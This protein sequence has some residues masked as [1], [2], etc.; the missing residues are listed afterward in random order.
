VLRRRAAPA[1]APARGTDDAH[2]VDT[3]GTGGGI[4][5]FN[6]STG[7]AILAASAGA[8]VA[9]HGNRAVTSSCGSADV[10]EALGVNVSSEP[11]GA[12][13]LLD[14]AGIAFFFAPTHHPALRHVGKVRREL[15][16]RTVFN[17]LG[18]LANPAG[19]RRQ[20]VGVY[21]PG[22]VRPMAEALLDLGAE[23]ALVV[24]GEEGLDE[25]SPC[26]PTL[27]ALVAE[28]AVRDGKATPADF[29]LEP[30]S[31]SALEPGEDAAQNA[32]IL[33]EALTD[34]VSPRCGALLPS[35]AA[36]LWLAGLA[37][38]FREGA[39]LA[40]EAVASGRAAKTLERFARESQTP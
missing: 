35:A 31:P 25:I 3:C 33:R 2:L 36:A 10:L 39:R 40:R 5:S 21:E 1:P 23:R 32:R 30:L 22:L 11:E 28:G 9:K 19:A 29:G 18:P 13:R 20:L 17:Q 37:K 7:A 27:T 6:L 24:Y 12:A 26:G 16:V 15:G 38:D 14:R 34:P 4:P 8:K